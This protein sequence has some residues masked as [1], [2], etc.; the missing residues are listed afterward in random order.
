MK[1]PETRA[2][3][4]FLFDYNHPYYVRRN[5]YLELSHCFLQQ[6]DPGLV[7]VGFG[8]YR[9]SVLT[10]GNPDRENGQT[11]CGCVEPE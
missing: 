11:G 2:L 4:H 10:T 7:T 6:Q 1:N 8:E 9:F 5:P 3:V